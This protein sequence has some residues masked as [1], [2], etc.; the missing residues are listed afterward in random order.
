M[1]KSE[2]VFEDLT[3]GEIVMLLSETVD[4]TPC[5]KWYKFL[6]FRA[7]TRA[8]FDAMSSEDIREFCS[9][10]DLEFPVPIALIE[11]VKPFITPDKHSEIE[12][13]LKTLFEEEEESW[14]APGNDQIFIQFMGNIFDKIKDH[15][16]TE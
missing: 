9:L 7:N 15:L 16:D 14:L 3:V 12:E 2:L 11:A 8:A 5:S 13:R 1:L 10:F 4:E 6:P